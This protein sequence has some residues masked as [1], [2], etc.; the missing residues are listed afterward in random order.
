VNG[1]R[2]ERFGVDGPVRVELNL[3]SGEAVFLPGVPDEV[4]VVIEG[5][6][7][8]EFVVEKAGDRILLETPRIWRS[9]WDSFGITVRMPA[10]CDLRVQAASAGVRSEVDLGSLE[11]EVASGTLAAGDIAGNARVQSAS[12]D[13]ALGSVSRDLTVNTASGDIRARQVGGRASL[14]SA[15]GDVRVGDAVGVLAATTQSGDLEVGCYGGHD[16]ECNSASGD[17]KIGL[18]PGLD[19]DVDVDT[20]SGEIHSD[21]SP[22]DGDGGT[23]RLRVKTISGDVTL[24]RANGR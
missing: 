16:L 2:Q 19:L 1:A 23:A 9:R 8:N 3:P 20:V 10:G 15:S 17:V 14:N 4:E 22:D 11:M 24:A 21:F 6:Q 12:G 18:P 13:V 7:A 5:R